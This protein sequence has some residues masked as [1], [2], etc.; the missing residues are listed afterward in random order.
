MT[1]T[2]SSQLHAGFIGLGAMGSGMSSSLLRAGIAV[3]G[4]DINPQAVARLVEAGGVAAASPA[5]AA[6]SADALILMVLNNEQADQVLFGENGAVNTLPAGAVVMLCS[7]VSPAYVRSLGARLTS[8]NLLFLDSPV[9]G[10]T[11]R[12]ALGTLSVMASGSP[13]AFER[14]TPFLNALAENLYGMGEEPGQGATMKL[15]N[16]VL[17]GVHIAAA[18]EAIALGSKAGIDPNRIFE[19]ISSSA[20]ASWMFQN[21]VPHILADDYTPHS[22]VDI[23]LKDLDL[24][25]DTGKELHVPTPMAAVAHQLFVMAA[26]SGLGRLDDAAVIKIY[27][28]IANFRVLDS[29]APSNTTEASDS[30]SE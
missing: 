19:V 14:A 21:R 3:Q 8:R 4:Y 2:Q 15:V 16:Q 27:E 29:V 23:W 6:A 18:A 1:S 11:A 30:S 13:A 24:V 10:G 20:G 7:T 26:S 12:A 17:A 28:K 5:Q 9:S 22:S 25:V